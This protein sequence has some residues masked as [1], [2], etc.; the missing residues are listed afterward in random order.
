MAVPTALSPSSPPWAEA[1]QVLSCE[2]WRQADSL[3]LNKVGGNRQE[4]ML[5]LVWQLRS[6]QCR[7]KPLL[8]LLPAVLNLSS[9]QK[10]NHTHT[11]YVSI[12]PS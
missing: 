3:A 11:E 4:E 8:C 9:L 12:L 6:D 2:G 10:N 1:L 7:S 5:E